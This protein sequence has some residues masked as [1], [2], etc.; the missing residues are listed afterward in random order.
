M[1]L[2]QLALALD[3]DPAAQ[4]IRGLAEYTIV[5][6][7]PL[8]AVEFDLDPRFAISRVTEACRLKGLFP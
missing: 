2:P 3:V 5:A 4:S 8:E 1:V 6:A 7:A